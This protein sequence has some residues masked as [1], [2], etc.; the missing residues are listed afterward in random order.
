MQSCSHAGSHV[1][2][3]HSE[4]S[5]SLMSL[6]HYVGF[7]WPAGMTACSDAR[8]LFGSPCE[9]LAPRVRAG[10]LYA[11]LA[12]LRFNLDAING[13][14]E[15]AIKG[16]FE[17]PTWQLLWFSDYWSIEFILCIRRFLGFIL[18][19]SACTPWMGSVALRAPVGTAKVLLFAS[20][21]AAGARRAMGPS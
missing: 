5:L 9:R 2:A 6:F 20:A 19:W 14:S 10:G 12:N 16:S 4:I 7:F 3:L 1:H 8:G 11:V 21:I 15:F 13:F 18:M 17:W